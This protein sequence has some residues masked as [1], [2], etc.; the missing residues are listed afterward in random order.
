MKHCFD[1]HNGMY[2][3]K[4]KKNDLLTKFECLQEEIIKETIRMHEWPMYSLI[5]AMGIPCLLY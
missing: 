4:I 3:L 1:S 5:P 2:S